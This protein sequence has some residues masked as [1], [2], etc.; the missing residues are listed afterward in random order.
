MSHLM[1]PLG[2]N[3]SVNAGRGDEERATRIQ[4]ALNERAEYIEII[5]IKKA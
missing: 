1:V 2:V 4:S 3:P 5:N